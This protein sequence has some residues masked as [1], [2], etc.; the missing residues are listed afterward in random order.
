MSTATLLEELSPPS[1]PGTTIHTH[2]ACALCGA[3][4]LEPPSTKSSN[5]SPSRN[6]SWSSASA[7]FKN[8]LTSIS[9]VSNTNLTLPSSN[10]LHNAPPSEP[11]T[12]V[13]IFRLATSSSGLPV[14]IQQSNVQT[15][16]TIYPLCTTGW[17]LNRLRTTCSL[18]A[19][20]RTGVVERIWEETSYIPPASQEQTKSSEPNSPTSDKPP[21]P[22]ARRSRMG[23]GALWGSMQR[24]LSGTRDSEKDPAFKSDEPEK[25]T[26]PS[27]PPTP[28]KRRLPPPPP[29]HPPL[30]APIPKLA[31]LQ[32]TASQAPSSKVKPTPPPL[33]QRNR[34]RDE[35][36]RTPSHSDRPPLPPRG[37]TSTSV[38]IPPTNGSTATD[39]KATIPE[40][41]VSESTALEPEAPDL[42]RA[43]SHDSFATAEYPSSTSSRPSSPSTIPLPASGPSTPIQ[44][45]AALPNIAATAAQEEHAPAD[46]AAP[47][48]V[49]ESTAP[50]SVAP[51]SGVPPPLPRRAAAR[52]RPTSVVAPVPPPVVESV[53]TNGV[54][55]SDTDTKPAEAPTETNGS[56][57]TEI[58]TDSQEAL[59]ITEKSGSDAV[60]K[61]QEELSVQPTSAETPTTPHFD[62]RASHSS[63]EKVSTS[64]AVVSEVDPTENHTAEVNG[65]AEKTEDGDEEDEFPG[66]FVTDATWEERTWK[67]LVKLREYM[68][69]ARLGGRR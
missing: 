2:V 67:E 29:S 31:E 37:S 65:H 34:T 46:A 57:E 16:P 19:F 52:T 28:E 35:H 41:E 30:H 53:E 59:T 51:V 1:I 11:P 68:F 48:P 21:P 40:K 33:P 50:A 5:L 66:T 43:D 22:P 60:E 13:Y 8:P 44:T 27:A 39:Q 64:P 20:V 3:T 26:T 14:S 63:I 69:W 23:I 42:A 62:D 6:G 7:L 17:C 9:N 4:I 47:T 58:K 25:K 12:Q 54:T 24:G 18:W 38:T 32:A 49:T 15:R 55:S 10:P 45:E 36:Q 61:S 56:H